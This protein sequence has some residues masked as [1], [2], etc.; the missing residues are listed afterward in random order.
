MPRGKKARTDEGEKKET[1][2]KAKVGKA[3]KEAKAEPIVV[4]EEKKKDTTQSEIS[5][6]LKD[7]SGDIETINA[8]KDLILNSSLSRKLVNSVMAQIWEQVESNPTHLAW[9]KACI[10]VLIQDVLDP[11]TRIKEAF[12]FPS[13]D[14]EKR[15]LH[16]I[17]RAEKILIVAVF[18]LT[19]DDLA[20]AIRRARDRGVSIRIIS[21]DDLMRMSGSDIRNL[22]DEG[23]QV[24]VDLDPHAQMH[25]KFCVID[26][27]ILITG[28]FNWTK[29]AVG[30]NQENLVVMD[31]PVL[32]RIYTEEF[33][34]MWEAFAASVDRYLGGVRA[35]P[36]VQPAPPA[37]E[38]QNA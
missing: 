37:T 10:N 33:N 30:K 11:K 22:H 15:L 32:A 21:D 16:Y 31:D 13:E 29:Q 23:I 1:K 27:Y 7:H 5:A 24:R 26:D 6:F 3:A 19:N 14:S 34:R 20:N 35:P 2:P 25:H 18:T 12:F 38:N 8:F 28:S 36:Q 17:N 4:E 9:G